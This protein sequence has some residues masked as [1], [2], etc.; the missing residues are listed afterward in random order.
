[1]NKLVVKWIFSIPFVGLEV[2]PVVADGVMYIT[3]PNEAFALDSLTGR[4]I[5][6]YSRPQT[7]GLVGDARLGTNR[8]VA[9]LGDKV[10]MATDN[11]HLIALNRTTG[12]VVWEEVMPDEPQHYGSTS[13][14]LVIKDMVITGVSGADE[15]IR[16]FIAAY[17]AS[18]GERVWRHWTIPNKGEPGYD[19]W[20]GQD[21]EFGGG[22]TWLTGAYDP[23]TNTLYWPTGNPFPD[24][25][26]RDRAGD[27][28]F[29]DSILALNPDNGALKW[30]Y[31]FT[32]HDVRDWDATEPPVLV[33]TA[34][35]GQDRKLL[36]HADRNGFFYVLDRTSGRLLL[37][38]KFVNH[39]TWASGIGPDGRPQ[40]LPGYIPPAEGE[41]ACP[42]SATNWMSTAFS[43]VTRLYYVMVVEECGFYRAPG[44][45]KTNSLPKE[46]GKK[47]LR[48]LDIET[49]RIIWEVPQIGPAGGK[50]WAGVL[51]TAGGIVLYGDP[52]GEFVAADERDGRR[53]WHFPTNEDV[54]A[55][56]MTYT[57]RGKQFVA[58]AAGPNVLCFGLP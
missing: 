16:G 39:L 33:D 5:W 4:Q 31:Q 15:G 25:D 30:Y 29:T 57:V 49:G 58:L 56:P 19:T 46:P 1:V 36:L 3:G 38:Q 34:Y 20:K 2:T 7:P 52:S 28:L 27:N 43:P 21:P 10:F 11:A 24:G 8:G 12:R 23:E 44:S 45:W 47:Y 40:L 13:A 17:N 6:H 55:S 26:D 14:P 51:A 9:L 18:T 53:L 42:T 37:G 35:H 32:P 50:R 54:K 41:M 22:S 48:A